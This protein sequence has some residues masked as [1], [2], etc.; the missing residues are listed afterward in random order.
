MSKQLKP[1]QWLELFDI[2]E[3]Q[4]IQALWFKYGA[5]R[6][7]NKNSKYLFFKK[8]K[9][10]LCHNRDMNTLISMTGKAPK[11]GTK[12]G[13]PKNSKNKI[14]IW[15]EFMDKIGKDEI[16]NIFKKMVD[17]GNEDFIDIIKEIIKKKFELSSRKMAS[18]LGTSKSSIC[19]L[20]NSKE[21]PINKRKSHK[22]KLADMIRDILAEYYSRIGREPI[23]Q[24]ML[25]KYG[26]S[27]SGRQIGRIMHENHL[28]CEIRVARKIPE[29]KDTT[30]MI[31][32]L[33]KRDYDNKNHKQIIR[34]NDVTYICAPYDA[35]QNFVYLSVVINHRTKEIES[36]EL[37]MYNDSKLIIDSF[38]AIKHKLAGS[39]VHTDHGADYT[40]K[41]YQSMLRKYHATQSMSRVGNS[42]DNRD[43]EFWFSIFKTELIYRLDIK[44][45]SFAQLRQAIAD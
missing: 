27:I 36:W 5:Y 39:I 6:K 25:T 11:K 42:L 12:S 18:I 33:V 13:R 26:I 38:A 31:P 45:M 17:D 9:K 16:A 41:S 8:Y 23:A 32:D 19:N 21:K 37:S 14:E 22:E 40:S 3:T 1:N 24:I 4:G 34:A 10:F 35:P 28:A 44:R 7:I 2:Y 30:A 29:R 43:I 15:K 20:R